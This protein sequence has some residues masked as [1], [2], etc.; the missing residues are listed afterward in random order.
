MG[1]VNQLKV[2]EMN[3]EFFSLQEK[4]LRAGNLAFF[5]NFAKFIE[6]HRD[7]PSKVQK[8]FI[9]DML[10]R[11][12]FRGRVIMSVSFQK[13]FDMFTTTQI[14]YN[15]TA[16]KPISMG[17]VSGNTDS[18]LSGDLFWLILY[19]IIAEP[20]VGHEYLNF[21]LPESYAKQT[22]FMRLISNHYDATVRICGVS[23]KYELNVCQSPPEDNAVYLHY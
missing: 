16:L 6:E 11:K 20:L 3:A 4:N 22:Y 23:G 7:D 18:S 19:I 5:E 10:R 9:G 1:Y 17:Y 12:Q 15:P 14:P 2:A 8:V 21:T 13:L